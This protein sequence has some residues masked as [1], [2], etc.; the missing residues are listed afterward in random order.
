MLNANGTP[1]ELRW[2]QERMCTEAGRKAEVAERVMQG[3]DLQFHAT[4]DGYHTGLHNAEEPVETVVMISKTNLRF[5]PMPQ[6]MRLLLSAIA[7]W[8]RKSLGGTNRNDY[9]ESEKAWHEP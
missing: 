4:V 8:E 9:E 5:H 2:M 3:Y 1:A 6:V 7:H